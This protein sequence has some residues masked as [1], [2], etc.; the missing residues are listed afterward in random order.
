M[1]PVQA[2]TTKD[3]QAQARECSTLCLPSGSP[4]SITR[5]FAPLCASRNRLY[6]V[7]KPP[8]CTHKQGIHFFWMAHRREIPAGSPAEKW[9]CHCTSRNPAPQERTPSVLHWRNLSW[10]IRS[11]CASHLSRPRGKQEQPEEQW[12]KKAEWTGTETKIWVMT[13]GTQTLTQSLVKVQLCKQGAVCFN[14]PEHK[15]AFHPSHDRYLLGPMGL[16]G[17]N[18]SPCLPLKL[19]PAASWAGEAILHSQQS[20]F[21]TKLRLNENSKKCLK[22][23]SVPFGHMP[24]GCLS[25]NEMSHVI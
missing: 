15:S 14:I 12:E 21:A 7:Q 20:T 24:S 9:C 4:I 5:R 3:N 17:V 23:S 25:L 22:I 19:S 8:S 1:T 10:I 18:S 2:A 13:L 11:R 16:E 6:E